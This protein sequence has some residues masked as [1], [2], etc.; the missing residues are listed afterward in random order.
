[1]FN[2]RYS[3]RPR[4]R[5]R[6]CPRPQTN[7]SSVT[8]FLAKISRRKNLPSGQSILP[9]PGARINGLRL[10]NDQTVLDQAT[11]ILEKI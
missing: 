5:P 9:R 6:P 7:T 2:K 8:T 1:M 4:P 10:L 11:N 3:P